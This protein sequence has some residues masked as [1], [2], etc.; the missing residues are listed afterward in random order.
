M[1]LHLRSDNGIQIL[2]VPNVETLTPEEIHIE[3]STAIEKQLNLEKELKNFN[4]TYKATRS[5]NRPRS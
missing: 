3:L 1:T 2:F 4:G 5:P